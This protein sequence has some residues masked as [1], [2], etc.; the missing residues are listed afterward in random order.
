MHQIVRSAHNSYWAANERVQTI[1]FNLLASTSIGTFS[2]IIRSENT[3]KA[4][5]F[6]SSNYCLFRVQGVDY[7]K[8]K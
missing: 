1:D 2:E 3:E 8:P 4:K 5:E 6:F 7:F